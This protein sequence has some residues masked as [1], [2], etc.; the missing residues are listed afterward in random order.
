M[1]VHIIDPQA[2]W[3]CAV[4]MPAFTSNLLSILIM[5]VARSWTPHIAD[6]TTMI[7]FTGQRQAHIGFLED[8]LLN[9][10]GS[11]PVVEST[12]EPAP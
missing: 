11:S 4:D 10:G 7:F 6:G 1:V 9:F 3:I 8:C 5:Y 12:G 2:A